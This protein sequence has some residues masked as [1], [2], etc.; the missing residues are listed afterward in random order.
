MAYPIEPTRTPTSIGDFYVT[1]ADLADAPDTV[2]GI[3]EVRDQNGD[4][5]NTWTGS[6]VPHLTAGQISALQS[7]MAD[8][9][10]QAADQLL[11]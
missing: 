6:L 10:S 11:P 7:F 2:R 4:V 8:L 1:L 3:I 9:R 5:M